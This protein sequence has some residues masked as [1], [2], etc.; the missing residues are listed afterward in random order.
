MKHI[1]NESANFTESIDIAFDIINQLQ[2]AIDGVRGLH[3]SYGDTHRAYS[4]VTPSQWETTV[5]S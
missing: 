4:R 2:S 1:Y 3:W 5:T